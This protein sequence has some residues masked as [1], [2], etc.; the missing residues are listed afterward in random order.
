MNQWDPNFG[1]G[2]IC[3]KS[4]EE[5]DPAA[6]EKRMGT[7]STRHRRLSQRLPTNQRAPQREER[8]VDVGPLVIPHA[9]TAKLIEPGKRPLH[10]PPPRAQ[11]TPVRGAT[12][13]EPRHDM[14]GAQSAP[15]RRRVVAA[16]PEHTVRPLPRSPPSAVQR[17]NRID[18]R[19]GF[20]RV[21]PVRAGQANRERHAPPVA[22]Q[23]ATARM[24]QLS[25]TAR[26]QSIWSQR[27][28]Q[29]RSAKWIRSHGL[30]VGGNRPNSAST[31]H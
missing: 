28:S 15:N 1:R 16:I 2:I 25:T 9:Q 21:V 10:D 8:L 4:T 7:R 20:L 27:A 14:P 26:D 6:T 22:N 11:S 5:G 3:E 17:G 18:Q 19:Q 12:H 24:E 29:S 30:P 23:M 31:G 13:G